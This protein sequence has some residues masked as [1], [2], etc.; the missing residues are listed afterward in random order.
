MEKYKRDTRCINGSVPF[1]ARK[2]RRKNLPWFRDP[3]HSHVDFRNL[4]PCRVVHDPV[5]RQ[6]ED[7]LEY[8]DRLGGAWAVDAVR[9]D[10]RDGGVIL[11][12]A[13]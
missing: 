6:I 10:S 5:R 7:A 3:A 9:G 13:V 12:D 1:C 4:I 8:S 11:G 2:R